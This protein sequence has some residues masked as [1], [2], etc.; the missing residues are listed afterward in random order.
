MWRRKWTNLYCIDFCDINI[1]CPKDEFAFLNIDML[2]DTNFGH[3]M[4]SFID[5]FS[6]YSKIKMGPLNAKKNAFQ[7]LV[8]NFHYIVMLFRCKNA[9]VTY[10]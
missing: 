5:G 2:V 9:G 7:T 3:S 1:S 6:D 10:Q 8:G 4:F